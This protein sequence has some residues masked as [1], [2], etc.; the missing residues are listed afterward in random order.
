[1]IHEK[2]GTVLVAVPGGLYTLGAEDLTELE[3]PLHRVRLS[4]FRIARHPVTNDQYRRFL[5][6]N[7]GYR[8]PAFWGEESFNGPRQPVVGVSWE[9]A[10]A[11][12]KWAGLT[13]PT[14]A[15]WEAAARGADARR[16]PWGDEEPTP[17]RA[18]YATLAG[19]TTPVDDHP[20]GSGPFGTLDMAGN[21]AEWCADALD[22]EA[23]AKRQEGQLDPVAPLGEPSFRVL[24]GGSWLDRPS[25]LPAALRGRYWARL[26]RRFIGFRCAQPSSAGP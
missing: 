12:C 26:R 9:D 15:Q 22:P 2:D 14:E 11:Y 4:P 8:K 3:Q 24:R 20:D 5:E 23:Y 6:A 21:V 7:P 17:A 13:L 10:A 16:Y 25:S 19:K 18:N 1:M